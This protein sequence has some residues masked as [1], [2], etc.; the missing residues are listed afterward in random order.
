MFNLRT[1][2]NKRFFKKPNNDV[3]I[4]LAT[5]T[6]KYKFNPNIK[7]TII[8]TE[9]FAM[10]PDLISKLVYGDESLFDY[11]LTFNGISNPLSI[12]PGQILLIPEKEEMDQMLIT[13]KDGINEDQR[14]KEE[15]TIKPE[16]NKD[17]KRLELIKQKLENGKKDVLPPNIAK[18]GTQPIKIENGEIIFGQNTT[19]IDKENCP[20]PLSRSLLK[21]KLLNKK[22][23]G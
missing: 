22:I 6:I 15:I 9:E 20:I 17:Q 21:E 8:V 5:S 1:L 16:S 13:P 4:D 3:I 19:Q 7:E 23:F 14:K 11:I 12:E 2:L 10:R 18:P